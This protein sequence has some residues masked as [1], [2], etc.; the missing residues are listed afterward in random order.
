[1][2]TSEMTIYFERL[3]KLLDQ[4][5]Q[6]RLDRIIGELKAVRGRKGAVYVL[7]NGGS[8]SLAQHLVLHLRD[9]QIKAFDLMA[10]PAWLTAQANDKVYQNAAPTLLALVEQPQ[11]LAIIISGSAKSVNVVAAA[12][13]T[14]IPVIGILGNGGEPALKYCSDAIVFPKSELRIDYGPLEDAFSVI[15]HMIGEA[16]K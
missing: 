7:G 15:I 13:G 5:P 2:Q 9:C 3:N 10:D 14:K 4:I 8:E 16:L 6:D 1:M 12:C 11:D